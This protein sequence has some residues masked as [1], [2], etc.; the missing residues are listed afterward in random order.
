MAV[1]L[2]AQL[3]RLLHK[4]PE[5]ASGSRQEFFNVVCRHSG[6][7]LF[8]HSG[9]LLFRHSGELFFRHSGGL[10]FRHSGEL[11]FRHSG[12]LLFRRSGASR[13]PVRDT[14]LSILDSCFRRN[15]GRGMTGAG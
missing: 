11:L 12:E 7:L 4:F 8:R 3:R 13:K 15:G 5:V 9:E 2:V 14:L 1:A 10:L 6:E